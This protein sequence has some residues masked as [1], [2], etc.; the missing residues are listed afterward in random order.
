MKISKPLCLCAVFCLLLAS[1]E[2]SK[3][4]SYSHKSESSDLNVSDSSAD[5]DESTEVDDGIWTACD[6]VDDMNGEWECSDGTGFSYPFYAGRKSYLL[7]HG[8]WKDVTADFSSRAASQNITVD[9]LWQ[10]RYTLYSWKNSKTGITVQLPL[11]DENGVEKGVKFYRLSGRI[12]MREEYL[13]TEF[14][15]VKNLRY[16]KLAQDGLAF[17]AGGVMHLFSSIFPDINNGGKK[18]I[19]KTA[20]ENKNA[21]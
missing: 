3:K 5:G 1:C 20:T 16:F 11:S 2:S 17:K 18:F 7:Y 15:F 21:R 10:K 19:K 8:E 4:T 13:I 12:Y 14:V 6:Y 9:Q